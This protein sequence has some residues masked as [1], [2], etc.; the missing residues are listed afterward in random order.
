MTKK[1]DEAP[2]VRAHGAD[3]VKPSRSSFEGCVARSVY[4]QKECLG[5]VLADIGWDASYSCCRE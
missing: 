2:Q 5:N 3:P 4:L 1:Y